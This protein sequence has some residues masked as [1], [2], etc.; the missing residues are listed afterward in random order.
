MGQCMRL[1][2]LMSKWGPLQDR[3]WGEG[4][5]NQQRPKGIGGNPHT[6]GGGR[7][8]RVL[9]SHTHLSPEWTMV[10]WLRRTASKWGTRSW[11]PTV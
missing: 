6:Q 5:V 10:G 7:Q 11:R 4:V 9:S 3:A 1:S 2:Q 8:I